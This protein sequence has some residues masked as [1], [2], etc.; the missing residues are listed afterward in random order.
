MENNVISQ[1]KLAEHAL[2]V[3]ATA[4]A[5]AEPLPGPV[6]GC[7]PAGS[8][9][10]GESHFVRPIRAF[11]ISILKKLNSPL[12][13]QMLESD[14][15]GSGEE[16]EFTDE[17]SWEICWQFS[18]PTARVKEVFQKGRAAIRAAAETEI[19][20]ALD[21]ATVAMMVQAVGEQI[22]RAFQTALKY[23]ADA[24][25]EGKGETTFFR[26]TEST[27]KTALAG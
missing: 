3:G 7:F 27:P 22:K 14:K 16:V 25:K 13:R 2:R 24:G 9:Q 19:G 5:N 26:D 6:A 12:Y 1:E 20:E 8:I 17:E 15:N 10:V 18:N 11:D 23:K 21:P 4:R